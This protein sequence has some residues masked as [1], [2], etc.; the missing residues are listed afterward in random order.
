MPM[1][2]SQ[3]SSAT[4]SIALCAGLMAGI[5]QYSHAA[6][7]AVPPSVSQGVGNAKAFGQARLVVYG[8]NIYDA[9]LWA[10]ESFSAANYST[11]PFALELRY[12]RNFSGTMIAERSLK[13][14][15]RLGQVSDEKAAQWLDTMK[16]T[17]PDVKKGDQLIG[18]HRPD[19]SASFTLNGKSIGEVRDEEFTRLF[20]GIWLSPKTSEP[21]MRSALIG[22]ATGAASGGAKQ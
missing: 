2:F 8:F 22:M 6:S 12:L 18:I 14:M 15:R 9:K 19:G 10:A 7:P 13:E 20:F 3:I 16:K 5:G 1:F 11:E 4:F 17:F 21:K